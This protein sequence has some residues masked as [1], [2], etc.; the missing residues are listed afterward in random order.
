[1]RLLLRYVE[2]RGDDPWGS[3]R[4]LREHE[5]GHLV[6]IRRHFPIVRGLGASLRLF[7]SAGLC[8]ATVEQTL[9]MRAQL[10]AVAYSPEPDL[11]LAEMV[12]V[13]PVTSRE[14]EPH[15]GGYATGLEHLVRHVHGRPD[16][17]PQIDRA[18]R[19]LPQLD[20]LSNEQIRKAAAAVLGR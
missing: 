4:T 7:L 14:P 13:T 16:L 20:R 11:A 12:L 6:E 9:E 17:Y 18:Y 1:M 2:R 8:G 3:Y 15:P 10:A 5:C 19:I